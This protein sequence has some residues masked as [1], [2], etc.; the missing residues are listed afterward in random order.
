MDIK[1]IG[2]KIKNSREIISMS[3][4]T[5]AKILGVSTQYIK[6]I[7]SGECNIK[8]LTLLKISKT[9]KIELQKIFED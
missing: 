2:H 8:I 9:L 3:Q 7:E 6:K 5:L 4:E 1:F